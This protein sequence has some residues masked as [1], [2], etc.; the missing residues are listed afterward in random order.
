[1]EIR[2]LRVLEFN[3][4]VVTCLDW[5]PIF[6][7]SVNADAITYDLAFVSFLHRKTLLIHIST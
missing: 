7:K 5:L 1:M 6:L 2:I 3:L 4:T